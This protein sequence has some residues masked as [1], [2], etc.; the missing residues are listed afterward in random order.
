[1]GRKIGKGYLVRTVIFVA[2]I[3][4]VPVAAV[5][6]L[7][8]SRITKAINHELVAANEQILRLTTNTIESVISQ[9]KNACVQL[10]NDKVF[11][12]F[13]HLEHEIDWYERQT[14]FQTAEEMQEMYQY[15]S[16]KGQVFD[17]LSSETVTNGFVH[18]VYYIDYKKNVILTSDRELFPLKEFYDEY[19]LD[20]LNAQI[21]SLGL[22]ERTVRNRDGTEQNEISIFY[23]AK[24]QGDNQ[25]MVMNLYPDEFFEFLN[26]TVFM[27]GEARFFILQNNENLISDSG[28]SADAG[29]KVARRLKL[30]EATAFSQEIQIE[31]TNYYLSG[32]FSESLHWWIGSLTKVNELFEPSN[33]TKRIIATICITLIAMICVAI[34]FWAVNWYKP[35]RKI[36]KELVQQRSA[37]PSGGGRAQ[38][39]MTYI[40]D[41]LQSMNQEKRSLQERVHQMLPLFQEKYMHSLFFQDEIE[42]ERVEEQFRHLKIGIHSENIC[43]ITMQLR[44]GAISAEQEKME[45]TVEQNI[46][47]QEVI[48]GIFDEVTDEYFILPDLERFTIVL[49]W[50]SQEMV[51][52]LQIC[53]LCGEAFE[54]SLRLDYSMGISRVHE[55]ITEIQEAYQEAQQALSCSLFEGC[56]IAY[57]E[58]ILPLDHLK[59]HKTFSIPMSIFS[60]IRA[61]KKEEAVTELL[62]YLKKV[63]LAYDNFTYARVNN[64]FLRLLSRLFDLVEEMGIQDEETNLLLTLCNEELIK[65]NE[66]LA[67]EAMKKA[68]EQLADVCQVRLAFK[69][70]D[71]ISEVK[72]V[73]ETRYAESS[74]SL[75]EVA[76]HVGLNPDYLSRIFKE[77]TGKTFSEYLTHLRIMKSML[78]L[79]ETDMKIK[80]IGEAVGYN[81]TNYF[82]KVFKESMKVT[83]REYRGGL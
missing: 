34:L 18:S 42:K 14:I 17:R 74:L 58:D 81:S 62:T 32:V 21:G 61:G 83:P 15:I 63:T 9:M 4:L 54:K 8:N 33:Y 51:R 60:A 44:E 55:S 37:E 82:I 38:N 45:S 77:N 72:L 47:I 65:G 29:S 26:K 64:L 68:V 50:K 24:Y 66:L 69:N 35:I 10:K 13:Q 56:K 20:D 23:G 67:M 7:T 75:T 1:M 41:S 73:M 2:L 16:I 78:L 71:R 46:C 31:D 57:I 70:I 22:V 79:K 49:N 27:Q 19:L 76:E 80:D 52:L 59:S 53:G 5:G 36:M 6:I 12:S 30:Y 48:R 43:L 28:I 3:S 40:Y 11:S 39:E 25:V